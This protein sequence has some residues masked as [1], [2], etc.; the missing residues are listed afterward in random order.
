MNFKTRFWENAFLFTLLFV[1]SLSIFYKSLD[2]FFTQ[3][4]FILIDYFSQDNLYKDFVNIFRYQSIT[5]WRPIYNLYFLISGNLLGKFYPGYHVFTL[6]IHTTSAFM[7]FKVLKLLTKNANISILA[8]IIYTVHPSHF[9]STFWISG[10]ATSIGFLFLISS[11][12]L[13]L[14]NQKKKALVAFALSLLASEAMV[15]GATIFAV[16][17]FLIRR[18]IYDKSFILKV[19]S[20]ASG[21]LF[22]RF[23]FLTPETTFKTFPFEISEE[24]INALFYYFLRTLGF[25]ETS[26]DTLSSI[27]L[28]VWL[29]ATA[30]VMLKILRSDFQKLILFFTI[31]ALIGLFPFIL[32][33]SHLS[34]HYMNISILAFASVVSLG[35]LSQKPTLRLIFI[36][37]FVILSVANIHL[38]YRNNWVIKRSNITKQYIQKIETENPPAGTML[39]FDDSIIS[40]SSEAYFA[41]GTGKA[42]DFWFGGKNYTTC[43]SAFEN[44]QVKN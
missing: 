40:S 11:F 24:T 21:F 2:V 16:Y 29:A 8:A 19:I 6:I 10:S 7:V 31:S 4:D 27:I 44:C 38:T 26:S 3:D 12:H 13:Y 42:I 14:K 1:L 23:V 35:F 22:F 30:F 39:V 33:P 25:V 17:E 43:F 32:I 18:K 20:V 15:A 28:I 37:I 36:L 9:V 5:H 41:L 34:P